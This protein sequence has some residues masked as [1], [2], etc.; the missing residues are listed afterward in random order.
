[1]TSYTQSKNTCLAACQQIEYYIAS[2]F[3]LGIS[4][5][6]K[7][8]YK[9]LNDLREGWKRTTLGNMLKCIEE[10]GKSNQS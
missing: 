10:H 2:S 8:K 5:K 6:Q 7:Q 4:K 1:M 3:L 9:T